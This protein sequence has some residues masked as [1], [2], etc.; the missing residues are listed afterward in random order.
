LSG[1]SKRQQALSV[2]KDLRLKVSD[3]ER[4]ISTLLMG[5][6]TVCKY[7]GNLENDRENKII[8]KYRKV[9][10]LFYLQNDIPVRFRTSEHNEMY[11]SFNISSGITELETIENHMEITSGSILDVI[12]HFNPKGSPMIVKAIVTDNYIHKVLTGIRSRIY[13]FLD[14]TILGLEFGGIPEQIFEDIRQEVDTKMVNLCRSAINKL[15]TAY[16]NASSDNPE[17]WSHVGVSCRRIIEDVANAVFPAEIQP[18]KEIAG[19][20]LTKQDYLNRM[21]TGLRN[22]TTSNSTFKLNQSMI[23][24][25]DSFLSNINTFSNKGTHSAFSKTDPSRCVIYTYMLLGD[26]LT[27]YI[28][29]ESVTKVLGIPEDTKEGIQKYS[30]RKTSPFEQL[31]KEAKSEILFVSTSHEFATK[32]NKT[33]MRKLIE[34]NISLTTWVLD[35]ASDEI[36]KKESLFEIKDIRDLSKVIDET[37][38]ELCKFKSS[39]GNLH[40]KLIINTY[41][42]N[43]KYS[44]IVIDPRTENAIM[45]VEE[46]PGDNPDNR[47]SSLAYKKDNEKFFQE[48]WDEIKSIKNIKIYDCKL[49]S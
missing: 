36:K 25:V 16:E 41:D 9:S 24:Y 18:S 5:C 43:V 15:Q 29:S 14:E 37:L 13:D 19:H 8:P 12:N 17:S 47:K 27:Y 40:D 20:S 6:K 34:N 4:K 2:A 32:Y 42:S 31:L 23:E 35:P 7:L 45:K 22:K 39:L 49:R 3:D 30:N 46:L 44:Y 11:S 48:H 26:I 28:E 33:L 38:K 21:L 1:T 10:C